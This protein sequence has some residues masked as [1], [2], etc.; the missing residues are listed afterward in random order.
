MTEVPSQANLASRMDPNKHNPSLLPFHLPSEEELQDN[1]KT[2]ATS[3]THCSQ[4]S[5]EDS[6]YPQLN[7]LSQEKILLNG[8][9]KVV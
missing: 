9:D 2:E 4:L 6:S 5:R 8:E 1:D 3:K 7:A